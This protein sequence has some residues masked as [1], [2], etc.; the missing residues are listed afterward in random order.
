MALFTKYKLETESYKRKNPS[1]NLIFK[2]QR[3]IRENNIK[4][5]VRVC[6]GQKTRI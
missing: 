5:D 1:Q 2:P 6:T 4:T 3:K